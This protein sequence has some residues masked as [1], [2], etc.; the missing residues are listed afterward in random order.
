MDLWSA[1]VMPALVAAIGQ[2]S[3]CSE[4]RGTLSRVLLKVVATTAR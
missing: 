2:R 3:I 4:M 1:G